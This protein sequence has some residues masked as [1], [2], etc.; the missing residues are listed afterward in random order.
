MSRANP[1]FHRT[2]PPLPAVGTTGG[3]VQY[4]I[5]GTIEG[6]MTLSTFMFNGF[7][8][9]P[10]QTQLTTL[11]S[12]IST[13]VFTKY[14]AMLSSDWLAVREMLKVVHRADIAT[15]ISTAHAAS[16]GGRPAGHEPTEV[17]GIF[18]RTSGV[19]G[20][21]GRGRVS[22]PAVYTG[23]VSS[24]NWTGVALALVQA[25]F[26]LALVGVQYSDGTNNWQYCI[27]QRSNSPPRLIVGA[28]N[29]VT[30]TASLLLGT[31]RR[32]KIGRGK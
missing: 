25:A 9:N 31:V 30:Q 16:V 7:V 1:R 19:K 14:T 10:T 3:V 29:V 26:N 4:V 13:G 22:V 2:N 8:P 17:A 23:D 24:S 5:Q 32:R 27:G 28:A 12:N 21:H 6:Q 11:L 18:L 20:Q 15:V